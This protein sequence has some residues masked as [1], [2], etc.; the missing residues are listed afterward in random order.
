MANFTGTPNNDV[1]SG[2]TVADFM[3][4]LAG[5][6]TLSGLA[7][8]DTL[9]GGLGNDSLRGGKGI[10]TASYE[11]TS[12]AVTVN[13]ELTSARTPLAPEPIHSPASRT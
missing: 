10:D 12:N 3:Q 2:T 4:G 5:N 1:L 11:D 13:L 6:D 9:I 7:G 8:D